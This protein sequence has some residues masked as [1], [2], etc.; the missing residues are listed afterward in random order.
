MTP[1]LGDGT[2]L[3]IGNIGGKVLLGARRTL[4]QI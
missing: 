2:G 4:K 1:N 3:D